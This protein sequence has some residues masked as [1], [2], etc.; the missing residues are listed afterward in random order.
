MYTDG[1]VKSVVEAARL[2]LREM[3]KEILDGV[4]AW[5]RGPLSDDVSLVIIEVR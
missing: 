5:S 1:R 3:R 2:D 4:C